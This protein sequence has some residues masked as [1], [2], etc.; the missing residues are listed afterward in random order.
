MAENVYLEAFNL[1]YI[2]GKKSIL[3]KD[4]EF[5]TK[6]P[7]LFYIGFVDTFL[8]SSET[9][10]KYCLYTC[11]CDSF[12]RSHESLVSDLV[13]VEPVSERN[14]SHL[15]NVRL[16]HEERKERCRHIK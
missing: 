9:L 12:A 15:F 6:Y 13:E 11:I 7:V 10:R 4:I 1:K 8:N 3:D 5:N 14:S 16:L 2:T